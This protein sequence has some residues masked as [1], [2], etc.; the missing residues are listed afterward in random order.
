M[1]G[2]PVHLACERH[3][4]DRKDA[5][6]KRLE[7]R[8]DRA[9]NAINFFSEIL[10]LEN[11]E[12]FALQP[13]QAFIVG[14]IFGWYGADGCRRFRTAYVEM[15]KSSGKTPMAA[16][17]G[18]AGLVIDG[19]G[20]PEIYSAA[21]TREQAKLIFRD[22]V[23]YV[24]RNPELRELVERHVGSLTI[25]STHGVFRPVS[26]EHRSLDGLRVHMGLIDELHEHPDANVVG[27][28]IAGTKSRRNALIFEITNSGYDRHSVCWAHHEYSLKVLERVID[29]ESWF[30]Y[31]CALDDGDDWRDERVWKKANPGLGVVPP[32][33]YL[34]QQVDLANGMP[35]NENLV[36]RLNFC[37]WTEQAERAI[38]MEIWDQGAAPL[39]AASL[40]GRACYGGLDLAKVSD[41]SAFVLLFPPVEDREPWKVLPWFWVPEDD[42]GARVQRHH[43][44]Y[45]VWERE[46]HITATP[47]NTTDYAFIEARI[48]ELAGRYAIR[49][50]AYDRVFAAEIVQRLAAEGLTMVEFGQGF[51]SMGAPT[52]ELLRM[53]KAGIL[54]HGGHPVLRWNASNL[55]VAIDPAGNQKPDKGRSIEKIDGIVALCNALGR[56]VVR[57]G[58]EPG[59]I[60][61]ERGVLSV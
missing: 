23:G 33:K 41:L 57:V 44:P 18:L 36:R 59:S 34:R 37:Q 2:K 19:E 46:G 45:D 49:E 47:G 13:F 1:A 22:A 27:K 52:A 35:S 16:G 42:I 60:Y 5:K 7:W 11:G 31:V 50:I 15:G 17:I 4:R 38:P 30:A 54:Q 12:P 56:A 43:V 6:R 58:N 32:I 9:A 48:L 8:R 21:T 55:T 53:V 61:E 51:A 39:E 14:S 28:I 20:S 24:D 29:N 25:P 3:L 40:L 26:S 10:T